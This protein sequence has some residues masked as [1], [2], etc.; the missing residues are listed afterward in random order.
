MSHARA[1]GLGVLVGVSLV[2]LAAC[3][4]DGGPS[5]FRRGGADVEET[6]TKFVEGWKRGSGPARDT[7]A[8]SQAR[9]YLSLAGE[10]G[11][12]IRNA[13]V[14]GSQTEEP[15]ER[16]FN[17][18]MRVPFPPNSDPPVEITENTQPDETHATVIATLNY[19]ESAASE[20]A[21]QGILSF[22]EVQAAQ[23][24]VAGGVTRTFQ[25]EKQEDGWRITSIEGGEE[26]A[27]S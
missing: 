18:V 21:A 26:A 11:D 14:G 10:D 12:R 8:A 20:L 2:V 17:Q 3:G 27:S 4:E 9:R 23:E 7:I 25:L 19:T 5:E 22:D 13:K 15:L 24:Q 1:W 16:V 6:V